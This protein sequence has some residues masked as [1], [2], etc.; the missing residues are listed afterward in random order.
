MR[1]EYI[2]SF[3]FQISNLL[4]AK[5]LE[6]NLDQRNL[7]L[8]L[9][10]YCVEHNILS[11]VQQ[12]LQ[13]Q[14]SLP[15]KLRYKIA[16]WNVLFGSILHGIGLFF[17]L[18]NNFLSLCSDDPSNL[19]RYAMENAGS[20]TVALVL[21]EIPLFDYLEM[22]ESVSIN[23]TKYL[24]KEIACDV[25]FIQLSIAMFVFSIMN[26]T[27]YSDNGLEQLTSRQDI[28]R[29]QGLYAEVTWKYLLYKYDHTQAVICFISF[30][31]SLLFINHVIIEIHQSEQ[32]K[33][34]IGN[35]IEKI[36]QQVVLNR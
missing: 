25:T 27:G 7:L 4:N 35:L 33:R 3:F 22:T 5:H 6:L 28:F 13:E 16:S 12:F 24:P 19:L 26:C 2:Y 8:S 15:I 23:L 9:N 1:N 29:I 10:Q 36:N 11:Y 34:M 30:V 32:H 14:T 20:V 21:R 18:N 17:K 31:K